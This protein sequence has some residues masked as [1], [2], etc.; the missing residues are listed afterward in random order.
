MRQNPLA[1]HLTYRDGIGWTSAATGN[2]LSG[3]RRDFIDLLKNAAA[4][5]P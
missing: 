2:D 4:L 1:G 5:A 3:Y